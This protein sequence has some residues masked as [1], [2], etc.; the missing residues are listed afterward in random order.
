MVVFDQNGNMTFNTKDPYWINLLKTCRYHPYGGVLFNKTFLSS[1][2][3]KPFTAQRKEYIAKISNP[4]LPKVWEIASRSFG[5][6]TLLWGEIVRGICF[7]LYR[8]ILYTTS[9]LKLA[10][11]RTEAIKSALIQNPLII[12]V[13]GDM[14]PRYHRGSKEVFGAKAWKVVD[15]MTNK[16]F[17]F[18]VPK[19]ENQVINGQVD[20]VDGEMIRPDFIVSDDGQDRE[21]IDNEENRKKHKMFYLGTLFPCADQDY[22]P[23]PK[24]NTWGG[25]KHGHRAPHLIRVI[26]TCKHEDAS[27]E[28][29]AQSPEWFGCKHPIAIEVEP[30]TFVSNNQEMMTNEQVK[31]LHETYQGMGFEDVFYREYMCVPRAPSDSSFPASFQYYSEATQDLNKGDEWVRALIL[32]PA[33]TRNIK[34][35]YSAILSVG[36]NVRLA[37]IMLRGLIN[38]RMSPEDLEEQLFGFSDAMNAYIIGVEEAGLN[39]WIRNPLIQGAEKRGK[40]IHWIWLKPGTS[41]ASVGG[42]FGTG[43]DSIKRRRAAS[44]IPF[45][46]PFMP[47]HPHGH[48]WHEESLRDS[49]LEN[50]IRSYPSPAHWDALDTLGYVDQLMRELG[51]RFEHQVEE[52]KILEFKK[53]RS[54]ADYIISTGAW[55]YA[56]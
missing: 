2:F 43:T 56:P 6:S 19:S 47:T 8:F 15:P 17:A 25:L 51:L 40:R 34:S 39:D 37:K 7:R 38:K 35:A 16:S 21:E 29:L 13:F 33:R 41:S 1:S 18:C 14:S 27:I 30:G 36:I 11:S 24:T 4:D 53:K 22:Q 20:M 50:Q 32:D 3:K 52:D 10:E 42:D 12:E 45:Y 46:R 54:R 48:V 55:R 5:K 28:M 26:D 49:A 9:E 44:A 23:D 31:K